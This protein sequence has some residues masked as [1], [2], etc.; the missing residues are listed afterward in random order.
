[1]LRLRKGMLAENLAD[2]VVADNGCSAEYPHGRCLFA[3]CVGVG[4]C[5]LGFSGED[6]RAV[7]LAAERSA[8]ESVG[9]GCACCDSQGCGR[10]EEILCYFDRCF[11]AVISCES[12][13]L[14]DSRYV[15]LE[16]IDFTMDLCCSVRVLPLMPLTSRIG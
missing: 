5:A 12:G 16:R 8:A 6:K 9:E 2:S 11:V 1:M 7:G 14:L 3:L 15:G 10:L 4:V 13:R